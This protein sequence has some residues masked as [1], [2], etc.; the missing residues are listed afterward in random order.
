MEL[1]V[2][3]I[4][5]FTELHEALE[6]SRST[7]EALTILEQFYGKYE[8][9]GKAKECISL[10]L[11]YFNMSSVLYNPLPPGTKHQI[12]KTLLEWEQTQDKLSERQTIIKNVSRLIVE[13]E[14]VLEIFPNLKRAFIPEQTTE[15]LYFEALTSAK[16]E[17]RIKWIGSRKE[18]FSF[19]M[20]LYGDNITASEL[21]QRFE[22]YRTDANTGKR[23]TNKL[24]PADR[25]NCKRGF[26]QRLK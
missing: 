25:L 15:S 2:F 4:D 19:G 14:K 22:Q 26:I 5:K 10:L 24:I 9:L 3:S 12:I 11:E 16:P 20:D 13:V 6:Q 1:E 17:N 18:C 23:N 21:N 7:E 8:F